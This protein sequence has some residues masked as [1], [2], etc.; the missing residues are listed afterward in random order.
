MMVTW[1]ARQS[2]ASIA[3]P[4]LMGLSST[5]SP[6]DMTMSPAKMRMSKVDPIRNSSSD[7]MRLWAVA[8][9]SPPT[10]TCERT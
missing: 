5:Y 1:T 4:G 3:R 7:A 9:P 6:T 8:V 2:S 10:M